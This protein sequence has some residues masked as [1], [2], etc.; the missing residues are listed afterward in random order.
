[1]PSDKL[2]NFG[3]QVYNQEDFIFS[4]NLYERIKSLNFGEESALIG[5]LARANIYDDSIRKKLLENFG[6]NVIESI[7]LLQRLSRITVPERERRIRQLREF[8]VELSSDVRII[9]I[10]LA[11]RLEALIEAERLK[12]SNIKRLSEETL[13]FYSTIAHRLGISKLYTEMEDIAFKH[14]YPGEYKKIERFLGENKKIYEEKLKNMILVIKNILEKNGIKARTQYRVKRPYSIYR[15]MQNKKVGF[16]EIFDLMAIRIIT[17]EINSCYTILGLV[18]SNWTPINGRF[19]DWIANPKP[20]GYRSIQTT[21]ISRTG[22]KYEIQ[23]RTEEMHKEAE[24]GAAAHWSYKEGVKPTSGWTMRLK[25]FLENDEI[26]ENPIEALEHIQSEIKKDYIS[27]ITPKGEVISLPEG[28]TPLDFAYMVHTEVGHHTTGARVNQRFVS[29][30]TELKSGDVV[31]IITQKNSKPSRNWLNFVKTSKAKS[32]IREWFRKNERE[33]FI[34]EGK[35]I[36]DSQIKK[37]KKK[38]EGFDK[39]QEFKENLLKH[40][41]KNIES[42]YFAIGTKSVKAGLPLLKKLFPLK[43]KKNDEFLKK[44]KSI[45]GML[46]PQIIIEGEKNIDFKIARCCKPIKGEPIVAYITKNS[47]IKVHSVN[48]PYIKSGAMDPERLRKAEWVNDSS[49]QQIKVR[50]KGENMEEIVSSLAEVCKNNDIF[51]NSIKRLDNGETSSIEAEL[52]VKNMDDF[53]HMKNLL[54][55]KNGVNKVILLR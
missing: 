52:L 10:K 53:I 43:H 55:K 54:L 29:L 13:F 36:F 15:K 7:E 48:C 17:D 8:F 23:I 33:A 47:G 6:E 5:F 25:E 1:M 27:V 26:F 49:L 40:G 46:S 19:R 12:K 2:L 28:S 9:I 35:R 3:Q 50:I 22:D 14:L 18:H 31:E 44:K 34:K 41:Y 32:K 30:K 45:G 16:D 4:K 20:N 37:H 51:L 21:I 39:E 11:E 42:L 38:Y 24:Y